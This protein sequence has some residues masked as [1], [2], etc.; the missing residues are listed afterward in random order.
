MTPVRP[1]LGQPVPPSAVATMATT[2][3]GFLRGAVLG[4]TALGM[5]SLLSACGGDDGG[6]GG[7]AGSAVKFGINEASGS[8]PAYDR[9]KAMADA[10]KKTSGTDVQMNAVDH[11]TFQENINTYL[12]GSP[13]DVFTW[14]A[15]YR[16]AQFADSGLITDISD[17]WPIDGMSEAFKA[18]ATADDGKQ[19]FVPVSYYPWAVFYLKSVW[20][21]NGYTPPT[22][23][24]ELM[25]LMKKMQSDDVTPFAF[26]DKDGWPAM[27]T[28]D[29]LNMRINGYDFHMSLMQGEEE[30]D[31]AE[32][33]QVFDTW[34][35]LL[36]YHQAD[37]LG[38]T[39]QEAATS[40]GKGEC[41]MYL[42]GTFVV[43]GIPDLEEDLDFFTFPELDSSIGADALDAPIDGFCLA[44]A[45]GNQEGGKEMLKWLGTAE[46]ADAANSTGTPMIAANEN[47]STKNYSALQKKSA[48]VVGAAENIAQF[49]DRDTRSDF[50]STVIIPSLQAFLKDPDDIDGVTKS[51]QEQKESIFV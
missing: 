47:A 32:V 43:D 45:G 37:P 13:D 44:A 42:L 20:E 50:A 7:D 30:W 15:G 46:A 19:Y 8:G 12:Q 4:A 48:E 36:P 51:I 31:S 28:F 49:L 17:V 35:G 34:R 11:N 22:T 16:M 21:K 23:S 39:W 5:P 18:S 33:K 1:S 10:Y 26:A 3:R 41:G 9:L 2:R 29:I 6:S 40:L 24:D 25:T 38:R 27:G 14:F